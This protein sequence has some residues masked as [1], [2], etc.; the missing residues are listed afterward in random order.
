MILVAARHG[1][2]DDPAVRR[3]PVLKPSPPAS[4]TVEGAPDDLRRLN[5]T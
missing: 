1:R 5:P 3:S 2:S 4:E